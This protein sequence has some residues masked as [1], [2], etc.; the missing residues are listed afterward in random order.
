[1]LFNFFKICAEGDNMHKLPFEYNYDDID[2]LKALNKA[3]SKLGELNGIINFLMQL[4][5]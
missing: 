2:I 4:S 3:N 5:G 1:M